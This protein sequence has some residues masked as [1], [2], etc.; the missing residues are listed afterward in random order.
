M[1]VHELHDDLTKQMIAGNGD[2]D[3]EVQIEGEWWS[4]SG[5]EPDLREQPYPDGWE[6][7]DP[8]P[9][10]FVVIEIVVDG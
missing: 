9:D 6:A 4:V 1:K 8:D 2:C 10:T 7:G 5:V 3:V